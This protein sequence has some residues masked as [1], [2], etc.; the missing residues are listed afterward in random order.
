MACFPIGEKIMPAHVKNQ[1]RN[2]FALIVSM[3]FVLVFTALAAAMFSASGTNVQ[4]AGNH[5]K[6]NRAFSNAESGQDVM[7]F[8]L[9]RIKMPASTP[10]EYYFA[11]IVH[12]LRDDLA[13]NGVT[14]LHPHYTGIIPP[15]DVGA[16]ED[17]TF[18][19]EMK[20]DV[21]NPTVLQVYVTGS[22]GGIDKT[23][24]NDYNIIA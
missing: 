16:P 21:S 6:A 10:V 8:W 20:M 11:T 12:D 13:D 15:V 22:Y 23:V 3:I 4:I 5:H 2:G 19:V 9:N 17:G 18:S 14:R 1:K 7:R 24:R